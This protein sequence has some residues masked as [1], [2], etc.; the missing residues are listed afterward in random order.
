MTELE[1]TNEDTDGVAGSLDARG[2]IEEAQNGVLD[3]ETRDVLL[4]EVLAVT[5]QARG[6]SPD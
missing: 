5:K 2:R 3:G 4:K 6:W 1:D